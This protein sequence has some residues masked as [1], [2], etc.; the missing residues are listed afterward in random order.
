M[1]AAFAF[2]DYNRQCLLNLQRKTLESSDYDELRHF[3]ADALKIHAKMP[4]VDAAGAASDCVDTWILAGISATDLGSLC[5]V[6]FR[7]GSSLNEL[8]GKLSTV[9]GELSCFLSTTVDVQKLVQFTI[10]YF[11][12][13][14]KTNQESFLLTVAFYMINFEMY[15]EL[16]MG[17]GLRLMTRLSTTYFDLPPDNFR[18]FPK[19]IKR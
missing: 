2:N 17:I 16:M 15:Y 14:H 10:V 8:V 6:A 3:Y 18:S 7:V 12:Q 4:E 9:F 1:A 19:S 11:W 13:K 5:S